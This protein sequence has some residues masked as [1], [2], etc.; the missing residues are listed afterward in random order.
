MSAKWLAK[1]AEVRHVYSW[2]MK[3]IVKKLQKI[4]IIRTEL[5]EV[6]KILNFNKEKEQRKYKNNITWYE[7]RNEITNESEKEKGFPEK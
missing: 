4:K 1:T 2:D 5:W 7:N 6:S 3:R